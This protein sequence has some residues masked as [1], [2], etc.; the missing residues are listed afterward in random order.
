MENKYK[1]HHIIKVVLLFICLAGLPA[2]NSRADED[3]KYLNAVREFADN[4][5]KYGRD[6][7]GPND[8]P[9][10]VDGLNVDDHTPVTW[11]A[12]NGDRWVLSNLASQQNLFR[13]LDGLSEITG[14][15]KYRQAAVEA[16]KYAFEHLRSPNG[17]LY[18]GGHQAYDAAA[19]RPRG[20]NIHELKVHFPYYQLMWEVDPQATKQFIDAFWSGH[21]LDWSNLDM[22]RHGNMNERLEKPWEHEYKGG[23]VFFEG[24]GLSFINT[25]NDLIYAAAWLTKLSGDKEPLVWAK[26][27]AHRYVE[28]RHPKTGISYWMYTKPSWGA[29]ES[30]DEIIR[31]LLVPGTDSF[32][33]T[34]HPIYRE[35]TRG[36]RM[37]TPGISVHKK[38]FYW[39][40]QFLVGDMLG[41]EG[42]EFKKWALE[43]LTSFGKAS[44]RKR[45]NV[46]VPILTDGTNLEGYVCKEDSIMGPKGPTLEPVPAGPSDFWA[47]TM[48]YRVTGDDYMWEMANNISKGNEFG[49]IGATPKDKPQLKIDTD[50]LD[51]Y[52]LLA[53]L[54]LH[55]ATDNNGFLQMARRIGNNILAKR[56]HKGFFVA[57]NKHIYTKFDAIDSLVLLHLHSA[58][59]GETFVIPQAWPSMPYFETYY[60]KKDIAIDNQ[61]IY[62]LTESAEPPMSLQEA[63]AV[64]D[65]DQVRLLIEKGT[66]VDAREDGF[67]KTALHRAAMSGHKD[68]VELLLIKGAQID[69]WNGFP[70]GTPLDYAAEKGHK[71][72][73]ELL[74][75]RGANI[76]ATRVYPTGDTPLHSAARAGHKDIIKL[77][78]AKGANINA[79][80]NDGQTPLHLVASK[81]PTPLWKRLLGQG[82]SYRDIAQLLIANGAN[83]NVRDNQGR[84]PLRFAK[85]KGNTEIVQ[86]LRKHGAKE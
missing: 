9:L 7:Y 63:A 77:L 57:S 81:R 1:T 13:T 31:K 43:E 71:E 46:Y 41:S 33:W 76:N 56:F 26:R 62:T 47:Y 28:T 83:V 72:I 59:V 53:F 34:A 30:D 2:G 29:L 64:G 55:R 51:P 61:I 22:D 23:P 44:Y 14:D 38:V 39:Q 42:G 16:V 21:I 82:R 50:C 19:D 37:P 5:L 48:G 8:T 49:D 86:L 10:F 35:C 75:A 54:E 58:V 68:V 74:I 67:Y 32:P 84:T 24:R 80:N 45:D 69:A 73:A 3:S 52:A 12:P 85:R 27:L 11:I 70:G 18:W 66:D 25:G 79:K 78:I 60:R 65:I 4:V 15:P 40:S 6:I 36:S 20:E 17:L